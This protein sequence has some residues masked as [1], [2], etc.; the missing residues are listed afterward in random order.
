MTFEYI[1]VINLL[2]EPRTISIFR[3]MQVNSSPPSAAYASVNWMGIG[4]DNGLVPNRRQTIACTNAD[5][6]S[7]E[8]LRTNVSEL[9]IE[10]L[11]ISFK[12]MCLK[13][14]SAKWRHW[15]LHINAVSEWFAK[16]E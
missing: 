4:P 11:T 14:S 2:V 7:I 5:L 6:L 9:L 10:I 3:R 8:P 15:F 16:D 12:K 1:M 13:M